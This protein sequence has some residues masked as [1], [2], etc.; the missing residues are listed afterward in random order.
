MTKLLLDQVETAEISGLGEPHEDLQKFASIRFY[1]RRGKLPWRRIG[2]RRH[3]RLING[4]IVSR[5]QAGEHNGKPFPLHDNRFVSAKQYQESLFNR[6]SGELSDAALTALER[7]NPHASASRVLSISQQFLFTLLGLFLTLALLNA[8]MRTL[9]TANAL[10]TVYFLCAICFRVK[11]LFDGAGEVSTSLACRPSNDDLPVITILLPLY[12]DAASLP[13]LSKAIDDLDYPDE[14]KDV[15][16]LL[17]EDDPATIEEVKRLELDERYQLILVPRSEPRTKPKACNVGMYLARGELIVIYDA[18]DQPERDQLLKAAAAFQNGDPALA[19][20]QARLNYYNAEDNWLTRL[21]TLEYSLWFDWLLPALQKMGAPIPLGG[22]SNF[23]RTD[24]L[25]ELGGW[26]PYNV[27]ED[28]DLGI[29]LSRFGYR[30]E[31]IDSTTYEEAN[32]RIG[33]WIRQ[34]SRWMKGYLQ[35]WLVHMRRPGEIFAATG[36]TGL[37]TVQLFVAGNVFSA[38]IYPVLWFLFLIWL[39]AEPALISRLFPSPL[40]ELNL[41]ALTAGN[42]FFILLM[43]IAPLKRKRYHLC[44]FGLFSPVYWLLTSIAAFK[45]VRQLIS[46]PFFWE[47]TDHVI[48][49][50]ALEKRKDALKSLQPAPERDNIC[51]CVQGALSD[52]PKAQ[53]AHDGTG[54]TSL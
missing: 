47:K 4:D 36:W 42:I 30:T 34:R 48:S 8:P 52:W 7:K 1:A 11:L 26:D 22:T 2:D 51:A 23:F 45:G 29:R 49:K 13:S 15:K 20:V 18:E 27:T 53:D 46:D 12:D 24:K 38:L 9:I 17:E 50:A 44:V 33:N 32:S 16:L 43:M 21:F 6:F 39:L 54:G 10:V 5:R 19:C 41:F 31:L 28:A 37:L 25:I 3:E 35:T 14:K 40:L